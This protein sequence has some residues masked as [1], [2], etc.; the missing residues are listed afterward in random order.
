MKL[1]LYRI[2]RQNAIL[3]NHGWSL[4]AFR[5]DQVGIIS[6]KFMRLVLLLMSDHSF[7]KKCENLPFQQQMFL[8]HILPV[9]LFLL[10]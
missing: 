6:D 3:R 9:A 2:G 7:S 8:S 10:G 4:P 1:S 5:C